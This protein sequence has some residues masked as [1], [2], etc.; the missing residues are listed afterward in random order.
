MRALWLHYPDDPA[1]VKLGDEYLWGRD[2]LVAPV[3]AKGA[4][5]RTLYLPEG[6]WY[7]FWTNERHAGKREVTRKVDL[8]TL[9]LYVRA[10]AVLPLDPARQYTAQPA[11]GP[12]TIRVYPGHDG[13]FR[14]YEDDGRSLDYTRGRFTWTRLRWDDKARRL[15]IEPDGEVGF[16]VGERTFVVEV[17]GGGNP[18]A[19]KYAGKRVEVPF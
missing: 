11:D 8:A 13:E 18:R 6:D 5:E 4:T 15:A 7:D 16:P 12:T 2:L 10:G 9:P 14:L 19:V 3:V 17:V 1:A